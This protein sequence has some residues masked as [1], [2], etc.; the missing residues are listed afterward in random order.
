VL[1]VQETYRRPVK[2]GSAMATFV[3]VHGAFAGGWVWNDV[4]RAL[5]R[6]GHRIYAPTLTGLGERVHLARPDTNLDT[7]IR[8]I[9]NVLRY[10][11]LTEVILGLFLEAGV[12]ATPAMRHG[13]ES[14]L[15]VPTEGGWAAVTGK[16]AAANMLIEAGADP[17]R[18][19]KSEAATDLSN[20]N[21]KK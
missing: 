10:E 1:V 16:T 14:A 19:A 4:A 18:H 13:G 5:E 20:G 21:V 11:E 15:R 2:E 8:D 17:N 3:L 7:H 6:T 12:N 9:L